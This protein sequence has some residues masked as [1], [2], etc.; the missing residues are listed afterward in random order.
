MMDTKSL[1]KADFYTSILLILF[2]FWILY[3]AFQMPMK[4][5][6]GGVAN[7]WYVSPALL[8]IVIGGAIVI[9]GVVLLVNSIRTGG[10]AQ[11]VS[12][13]RKISLKLSEPTQRF[14]G[15]LLGLITFVYLYIPNTD[16]FLSIVLFLSYLIPAYFYDHMPTFRKLSFYY[17]VMSAVMLVVFATPVADS[18]NKLYMF[19]TDVVALLGIVGINI[20]GARLARGTDNPERDRKRY[21]IGLIVSLVTP[22]VL[23]PVFRFALLVP[24]PKEGGIVQLMQLIY[25][26]IR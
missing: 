11:A 9:L 2:G 4:D 15:V 6:Y 3:Q 24:L 16:F 10:A 21:R 13:F 5:T 14:L 26:S 20:Y 1:R 7:V 19:A 17:A 22:L 25:Y 8:P 23:T 12:S 18:L